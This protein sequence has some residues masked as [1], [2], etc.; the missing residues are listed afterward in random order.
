MST[1]SM[2]P[3]SLSFGTLSRR[4][5]LILIALAA[6]VA[7]GCRSAPIHDM[8]PTSIAG[9]HTEK[10]VQEAI[11]RAGVAQGWTMKADAPGLITGTL[12]I[13]SHTAV[14]S[15]PYTR[16]SFSI[17]YKDSTNLDYNGPAHTIHE[18]YNEWVQ[19]LNSAIVSQLTLL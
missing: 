19:R 4:L 10:Q 16:D 13:R 17:R 1:R 14:V 2:T 5:L 7:A 3:R 18:N 12:Y 8:G 15:I 9:R 6:A 11:I